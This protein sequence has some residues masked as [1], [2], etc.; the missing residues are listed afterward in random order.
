MQ[1]LKAGGG[2]REDEGLGQG[3]AARPAD[4]AGAF[5]RARL[6]ALPLMAFPGALPTTL[7]EAYAIQDRAIA[8]FPEGLRGWKVAGIQPQF[9]EALGADRLAGPVFAEGMRHNGDS[10]PVYF[11]VFNGGFA[12]VEAE[13]IFVL[14]RDIQPGETP[15]DAALVAAVA[16]MHAGAETAGSPLAIIN[17][18]G[19]TAVVSDFG[20]NNGVIIAGEVR[21][22]SSRD[23]ATIT[24]RT[25]INGVVVG[26][27]SAAAVA[28]GPLAA[29]AFL[30]RHL[31]A[32]GLTLHAGDCVSTGM[33]T[34]VHA[35]QAGDRITFDFVDGIRFQAE[36]IAARP[37][38]GAGRPD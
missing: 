34:G 4:I 19:P 10:R 8:D 2:F 9:R 35:V 15:D 5:R 11:P 37:R 29:L 6:A 32:R 7:A 28:G 21:D 16:S 25:S 22:W 24:A 38:S 30:V 18:L 36:A 1:P 31:G 14:G 13:F 17:D 12:A 27:G 20:N 26:E 3:S 23:P 33:T